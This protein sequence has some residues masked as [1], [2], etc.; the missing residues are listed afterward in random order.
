[1]KWGQKF[2]KEGSEKK[3]ALELWCSWLSRLLY[4]QKVLGSNPS[5]S[6]FYIIIMKRT[7]STEPVPVPAPT[8]DHSVEM[9]YIKTHV[10]PIFSELM[11]KIVNEEPTDV[12]AF[13]LKHLREMRAARNS[14]SHSWSL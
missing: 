8:F 7:S 1:M 10:D 5:S 12:L 11:V 2:N 14:R 13:M 4:T 3:S 6:T 9:E